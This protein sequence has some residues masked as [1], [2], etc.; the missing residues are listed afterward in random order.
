MIED[1]STFND[2]NNPMDVAEAFCILLDWEYDPEDVVFIKP[3]AEQC[4]YI[5][6]SNGSNYTYDYR[7]DNLLD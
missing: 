7:N 1:F 3:V 4:Y 6:L 2:P 5:E